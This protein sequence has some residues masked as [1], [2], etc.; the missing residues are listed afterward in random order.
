M[1]AAAAAS[2]SIPI[3]LHPGGAE[4]GQT[5]AIDRMLPSEE[6][7]HRQ[8][9]ATA[10]LVQTQQSAAH[11]SDNFGLAPD[12]PAPRGGR[13]QIGERQRTPIGAD[14]IAHTS[15]ALFHHYA[16]PNPRPAVK[17]ARPPLKK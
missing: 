6:F 12:H 17:L 7:L 14:D 16:T 3:L 13:G 2:G 9:I 15:F 11:R 5:E 8:R 1:F 4:A 10:S